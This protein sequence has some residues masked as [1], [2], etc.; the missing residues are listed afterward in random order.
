MSS[1]RAGCGVSSDGMTISTM[2]SRPDGAIASRTRVRIAM[3]LWLRPVVDDVRE[4]VRVGARG[5][6]LE[7]VAGRDLAAAGELRQFGGRVRDRAGKV[8]QDAVERCVASKHLGQEGAVTP[9]DVD[10]SVH[11]RERVRLGHCPRLARR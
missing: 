5:H 1:M 2:S 4:Q 7:E 6:R 3:R 9:A 11:S 10:E 8:E